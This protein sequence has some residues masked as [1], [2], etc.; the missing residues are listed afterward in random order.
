VTAE[1]AELPFSVR[2]RFTP[3][4]STQ[5]TSSTLSYHAVLTKKAD[6]KWEIA[7]LRLQ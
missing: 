5:V 4:N 3:G 6:G 7:E 1:R 2:L